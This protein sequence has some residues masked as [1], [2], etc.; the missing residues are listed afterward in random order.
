MKY[1]KSFCLLIIILFLSSC[2]LENLGLDEQP[3]NIPIN[4]NLKIHF[5][6]VGQGDAIFIELPNN[7]TLLIDAGEA[8]YQKKVLNYI[9]KLNY[10]K[11]DYVVGTHP[12]TDHIGGLAY[13][14]ENKDIGQIYLPKVSHNSKTYENLL[15]TIK[16]KGKQ[17]VGATKDMKIINGEDLKIIILAPTSNKF[18]NLNNA[19]IV[20]KIIFKDKSFLFMGDAEESVEKTLTDVAAD[21][22]KVG[23][24]GSDTSSSLAFLK[25]VSPEYAIISVGENNQYN[26]P[27]LEVLKRYENLKTK[28][29]RTDL[30]GTIDLISDGKTIDI[31]AEKGE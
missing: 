11:I 3:T 12:H 28:V 1:F 14:I 13:I 24:H 8:K 23:H 16:N 21:V 15:L 9:E 5:L 25:K 18:S 22:I 29:Y 4:D 30:N 7:E 6:D 27:S 31:K 17:V 26:H 20:L 10:E 2:S 19:S